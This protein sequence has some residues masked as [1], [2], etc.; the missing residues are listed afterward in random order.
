[1]VCNSH[2]IVDTDTW[3]NYIYAVVSTACNDVD[4][5]LRVQQ[6]HPSSHKTLTVLTKIDYI[7]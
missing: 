3:L 2:N 7:C 5:V 4:S 6:L 1:M